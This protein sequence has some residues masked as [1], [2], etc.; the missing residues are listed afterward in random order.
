MEVEQ[1]LGSPVESIREPDGITVDIYE[2]KIGDEPRPDHAMGHLQLDFL[3]FGAW[4]VV[5]TPLEVFR[6]EKRRVMV[7]YDA[8]DNVV[9]VKSL[10]MPKD[11][12]K[13]QQQSDSS[14]Q[15]NSKDSPHMEGVLA[16]DQY[17]D[18]AKRLAYALKEVHVSK[19]TLRKEPRALSEQ[20]VH[21]LLV[22][23]NCYDSVRN[24]GAVF[25]NDFVDNTDGTVT[26]RATSLMWHQAGSL[27]TMTWSQAQEYVRLLNESSFADHSDWRLPTLEEL[28]S[29]IESQ[30]MENRSHIHPLFSGKQ[31]D[32]WS[33]DTYGSVSA[34]KV[35]FHCGCIGQGLIDG[36]PSYL[37][38]RV[39]RSL[40]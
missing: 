22:R 18:D 10:Q 24:R 25:A 32:Y 7:K 17:R 31:A 37:Y 21:I 6:G 33:T 29:L 4:E 19:V 26:D 23:Y 3:T 27:S 9:T 34:W 5:G 28:A 39:V 2:Y 40:G 1:Q 16:K 11:K 8:D 38:V 14:R 35:D 15:V 20:D 12:K 36:Y 13:A 30:S